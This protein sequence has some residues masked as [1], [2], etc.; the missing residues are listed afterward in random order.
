MVAPDTIGA[1]IG[2]DWPADELRAVPNPIGTVAIILADQVNALPH[3]T[4]EGKSK[5]TW[6]VWDFNSSRNEGRRP[7]PLPDQESWERV[8]DEGEL[9][10][11]QFD[12]SFD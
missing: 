2:H 1:T 9:G 11:I 6:P 3:T 4:S 5:S 10:L 12:H 8:L 7:L